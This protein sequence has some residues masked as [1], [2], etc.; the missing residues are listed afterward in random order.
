M[1]GRQIPILPEWSQ[2]QDLNTDYFLPKHEQ[3]KVL[4]LPSDTEETQ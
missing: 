3:Q 4:S 2:A 1:P